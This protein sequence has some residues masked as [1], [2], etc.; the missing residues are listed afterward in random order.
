MTKFELFDRIVEITINASSRGRG[1]TLTPA[2]AVGVVAALAANPNAPEWAG[3]AAGEPT[4]RK[5]LAV[6]NGMTEN[7]EVR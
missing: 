5:V 4:L 1:G 2:Q 7:E 6:Y 3:V